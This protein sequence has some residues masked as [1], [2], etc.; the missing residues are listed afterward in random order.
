MPEGPRAAGPRRRVVLVALAGGLGAALSGCARIPTSGPV[1]SGGVVEPDE[2][3]GYRVDPVGPVPGATPE[4]VVRG[5]LLAGVG[6]DDEF[7]AARAFLSDPRRASWRPTA[8]TVVHPA[9]ALQVVQQGQPS[10]QP[11]EQEEQVT[12][13]VGTPVTAEVDD[14]GRYRPAAVGQRRDVV[15][16]LVREQ[17][18][19]RIDDAPDLLMLDESRFSRVFTERSVMFVARAADV[20]VP[21]P[22]WLLDRPATA[23]ALVEQVLDGPPEWLARAVVSGAPTGTALPDNS[24]SVSRGV[25][26]VDLPSSLQRQR[27]ALLRQLQQQT[28]ATLLAAGLGITQVDL[29]LDGGELTDV[30]PQSLPAVA[31]DEMPVVVSQ[32]RVCRLVGAQLMPLEGLPVVPGASS[33]AVRGDVVVVLVG[34][35]TALQRLEPAPLDGQVAQQPAAVPLGADLTPPSIDPLGWVWTTPAASGGTVLAVSAAGAPT[36]VSAPWLAGRRVIAMR[37]APDGARMLVTS[38]GQGG[39]PDA[40]RVD[41]AGIA[42]AGDGTPVALSADTAPPTPW[43]VGVAGAVW[44]GPTS[45]A[46][47][48]TVAADSAQAASAS[49]TAGEAVSGAVPTVWLLEGGRA[50][51]LGGPPAEAGAATIAGGA[52]R[53]SIVVGG[54]NGS[55]WPRE[56]SRWLE[57]ILQAPAFD[58]AYPS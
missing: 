23:T 50:T 49:Q 26:T 19:W 52:G 12:V 54:A 37:A 31:D 11:G 56:G 30:A 48:G 44:V 46:V 29:T 18:Q 45:V 25:A 51:Y 24:V 42:R 16:T 43:L 6:V 21:D 28:S 7:G 58:P 9:G 17:G 3:P 57:L 4:D 36:E 35:R 33:P 1:R 13:A 2:E 27:S 10:A 20:L 41:V 53:Q 22:R 55:I 8:L 14:T 15:M 47:L 40:V 39:Q 5:F 34:G 32:D 38:T